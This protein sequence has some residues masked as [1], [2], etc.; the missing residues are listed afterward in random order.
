MLSPILRVFN[1]ILIW[2]LRRDLIVGLKRRQKKSMR[3]GRQSA[4]FALA[5]A[6]CAILS[7]S[8]CLDRGCSKLMLCPALSPASRIGS[9]KIGRPAAAFLRSWR[10]S[11]FDDM[12]HSLDHGPASALLSARRRAF[13][14]QQ[15]P[16]ARPGSF[17]SWFSNLRNSL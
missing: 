9:P 1:V 17:A 13:F 6:Y 8:N 15:I 12:L 2:L 16:G 4:G 3:V 5:V 10:H 14:P 7:W 11:T